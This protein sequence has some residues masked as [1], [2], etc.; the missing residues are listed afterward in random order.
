MINQSTTRGWSPYRLVAYSVSLE[1]PVLIESRYNVLNMYPL[2]ALQDMKLP[3]FTYIA[4]AEILSIG[5]I[6]ARPKLNHLD[7][8]SV[9]VDSDNEDDT[10]YVLKHCFNGFEV[11]AHFDVEFGEY[12]F[13]ATDDDY[14][15]R[16]G[17][18]S[19]VGVSKYDFSQT[20]GALEPIDM[21]DAASCVNDGFF[22][23]SESWILN[24]SCK[25]HG[26]PY[27]EIYNYRNGE[28]KYVYDLAVYEK[29]IDF[30]TIPR[31]Q[32]RFLLC[33]GSTGFVIELD[34]KLNDNDDDDVSAILQAP[35]IGGH[36]HLS[37]MS[38]ENIEFF[39]N[40]NHIASINH[41]LEWTI[42]D[43]D[44]GSA[45][46]L[47]N[48]YFEKDGVIS[49]LERTESENLEATCFL[50]DG[51]TKTVYTNGYLLKE[52]GFTRSLLY[53]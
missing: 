34:E 7:Y 4:S 46:R 12:N 51:S 35:Y 38:S 24:Q 47:G 11:L 22:P 50:P 39:T 9:R 48:K 49:F 40:G 42:Y 52:I 15:D 37:E 33:C 3:R 43:A 8:L 53:I 27:A 26:P 30:C 41:D 45:L 14:V 6:S 10:I 23:L 25:C 18:F 16:F 17:I 13:Y 5:L 29:I 20:R 2:A 1:S 32:N 19:E 36:V 21:G 44:I 31:Y 28:M